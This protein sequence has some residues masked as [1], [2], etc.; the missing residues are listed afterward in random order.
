MTAIAALS[1][2]DEFKININETKIRFSY[3]AAQ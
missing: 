1:V 2:I 3:S